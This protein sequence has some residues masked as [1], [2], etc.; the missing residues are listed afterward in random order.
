MTFN[1]KHILVT[2]ASTGIGFATAKM[3]ALRGAKVSMIARRADVLAS[4]AEEIT[5]LGGTVAYES[6]DVSDRSALLRVLEK[7]VSAFGPLDGLFANAGT[8]GQFAPITA[9]TDDNWDQI[10]ATNMTSVFVALRQVLPGMIARKSGSIVIT[11]SLA[12]ERGMANNPAYVASKHAV[13]GLARA[14]ALETA[15]HGVRVNCL[16]PGL[17]ETPLLHNI[18]GHD[19]AAAMATLGKSVP[20]GRVGTAH[21]TAEVACFLLSDAAS[22]VTGQ[23]WAVDGGILGTLSLR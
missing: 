16:L 15:E 19:V 20:Q 13:L 10:I 6:A 5:R 8:G 11:G 7:A 21:E 14:A 2:G 12:S 1:G 3:L 9:C 22:H 4:S 23:A 18:G 17:I